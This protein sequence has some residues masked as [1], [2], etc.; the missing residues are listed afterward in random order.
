MQKPKEKKVK[1][2]A[3]AKA[4]EVD[5]AEEYEQVPR[6]K[7]SEKEQGPRAAPLPLKVGGQ[8]VY[9]GS[10]EAASK[11]VPVHASFCLFIDNIIE[12]LVFIV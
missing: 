10:K 8:L 9:P 7:L 5:D 3:P 6:G 2:P 12:R 11:P 1:E 4:A